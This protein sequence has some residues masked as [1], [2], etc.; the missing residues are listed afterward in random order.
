MIV[1]TIKITLAALVV[2]FLTLVGCALPNMPEFTAESGTDRSGVA[3][4][5]TPVASSS[6]E[7]KAFEA[8]GESLTIAWDAPIGP[9]AAFRVYYRDHSVGTWTLLEEVPADERSYVISAGRLPTGTYDFA[10]SSLDSS[11]NE[12]EKHSSRDPTADPPSGWYVRWGP[13]E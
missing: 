4:D 12:S 9:V 7:A 13:S 6:T 11:G 10:V 3:A 5:Q 1:R 2:G 8:I